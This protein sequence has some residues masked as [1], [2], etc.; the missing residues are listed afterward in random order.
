MATPD[1]QSRRRK[2]RTDGDDRLSTRVIAVCDAVGS[3]IESWG[4]RSIH[5]RTWTLLALSRRP[6]AQ[7]EVAERLGVSRS[8]VS[9]AMTELVGYGLVRATGPE[10]NAPYE[11]NFDVWP[12]ITDVLRSREWMLMEQARV[13]LEAAHAEAVFAD[14]AGL[15][16]EYDRR[17]IR[18]LLLMTEFAQT[19]LKAVL[20]VRMPRSMEGFTT[21]LHGARTAISRLQMRLPRS[22]P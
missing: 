16:A 14:N 3:F 17:R 12:I 13:A 15:P 2:D 10:R 7:S 21:W 11:A 5:G 8:L 4:F 22:G 18:W 1:A 9:L 6:L 20:S 19:T